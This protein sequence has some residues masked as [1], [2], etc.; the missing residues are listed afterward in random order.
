MDQSKNKLRQLVKLLFNIVILI[1]TQQAAAQSLTTPQNSQFDFWIG[2]WDL[3]ADGNKFGESKVDTVLDDHAIQENF[4]EFP[5]D[6]Y[7]SISFTTY[8][9]DTKKWE[10]T[11]V[12]NK[13]HHSF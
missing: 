3:Y 11:L 1:G 7:H 4:D 2:K 13:G 6:P 12:D 10:Q 8:N 9:Q 5:P